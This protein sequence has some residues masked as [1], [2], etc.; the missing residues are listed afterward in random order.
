MNLSA[1]DGTNGFVITSL[2]SDSSTEFIANWGVCVLPT[3][4]V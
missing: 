1:I 4:H 2:L 3:P